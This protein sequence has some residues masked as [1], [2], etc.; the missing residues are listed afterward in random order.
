MIGQ[1]IPHTDM[2]GCGYGMSDVERC[3]LI[4]L[5][6]H[7]STK[8]IQKIVT[9]AHPSMPFMTDY[10]IAR[11]TQTHKIKSNERKQTKFNKSTNRTTFEQHRQYQS[12]AVFT[13]RFASILL[14]VLKILFVS[15]IYLPI[16]NVCGN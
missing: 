1:P 12:A 10:S 4:H 6:E 14:D 3:T 11:D 2:H 13:E 5:G 9:Q 15:G 8:T 7:Q 16:E